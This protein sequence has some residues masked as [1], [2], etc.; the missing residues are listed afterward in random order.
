MDD[1]RDRIWDYLYR[2]GEPQQV[3]VIAEQMHETPNAIQQA[4]DDPWFD[5]R[6][7]FVAIARSDG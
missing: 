7:D 3:A 1:L 6:E 2:C 4:V 5:V